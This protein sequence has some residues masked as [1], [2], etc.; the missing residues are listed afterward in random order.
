MCDIRVDVHARI[1]L[2]SFGDSGKEDDVIKA[3]TRRETY[4]RFGHM[5]YSSR[6][7]RAKASKEFREQQRGITF[8]AQKVGAYIHGKEATG[9][10][11]DGTSIIR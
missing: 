8:T 6:R 9:H 11:R 3:M 1:G 4:S 10:R 5:R 7:S 2:S